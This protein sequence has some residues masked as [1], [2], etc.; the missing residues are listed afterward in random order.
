MTERADRGGLA[1][2]AAGAVVFV[3]FTLPGEL[4]E[5]SATGPGGGLRV[6]QASPSRVEPRCVHF[7]VCGG[8]QYQ[9]AE[10]PAQLGMKAEI[11]RETL[12]RAGV[13]ELPRVQVLGSPEPWGYRNRIRLRVRAVE[14]AL[15]LA[16]VCAA[17]TSSCR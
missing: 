1:R 16:I 10:Y 9:M 8:C 3:P 2:S 12:E 15:R 14:G 6:L 11:L 7:G 17:Q 5:T 4:V 13:A